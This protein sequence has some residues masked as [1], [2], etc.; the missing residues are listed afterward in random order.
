MSVSALLAMRRRNLEATV[1][2]HGPAFSD[3]RR[4]QR[5]QS[6][7][8]GQRALL[9]SASEIEISAAHGKW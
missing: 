5:G 9:T 8:D 6:I 7:M 1:A 4:E 3:Y 2:L